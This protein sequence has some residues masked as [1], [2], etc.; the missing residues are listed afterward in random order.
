MGIVLVAR[1]AANPAGVPAITMTSTRCRTKSAANSFKR[2]LSPSADLRST[3]R[4]FPS[5]KPSSHKGHGEEGADTSIE[6]SDFEA[7]LCVD[8]D[9]P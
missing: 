2:S 9:R 6:H 8:D 7:L 3:T 5:T 1:S 4:F